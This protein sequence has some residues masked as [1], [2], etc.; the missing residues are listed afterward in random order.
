[1]R[2]NRRLRETWAVIDTQIG[3]KEWILGDQ[4][5]AA[6][7]Y[8]FMLTTWLRAAKGHPTMVEFPNVKRIADKVLQRP[9]V[10]LVYQPWIDDPEY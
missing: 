3:D 8:L 1:M 7:I 6:D 2:G 5:S 10:R 4:F 9:S